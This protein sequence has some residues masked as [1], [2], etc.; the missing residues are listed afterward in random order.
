MS[1]ENKTEERQHCKC[2]QCPK[3]AFYM[4]SGPGVQGTV[5]L[6][7]DCYGKYRAIKM[8]EAEQV[9]R[10]FNI[11][12][13]VADSQLHYVR[14]PKFPPRPPRM[15]FHS[16]STTLNNI[17][18]EGGNIGVLNT[19]TIGAVDNAIGVLKQE[20]PEL[21]EAIGRFAGQ[22]AGAGD[23]PPETRNKIL[24]LLGSLSGEVSVPKQEGRKA[25]VV[26]ALAKQL[27]ELCRAAGPIQKAWQAIEAMLPNA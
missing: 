27:G 22:V 18:V 7:L 2:H 13:E 16:G 26:E 19:G 24:E 12:S 10:M 4:I 20:S 25:S 14:G 6:C 21:A 9:E 3:P 15:T 17:R 11:L 1:E 5:N 23:L 8:E